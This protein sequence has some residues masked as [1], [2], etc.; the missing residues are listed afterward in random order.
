LVELRLIRAPE[1]EIHRLASQPEKEPA[2]LLADAHRLLIAA[3]VA[4]GQPV[5]QPASGV[6]EELD[7]GLL[8]PDFLIQLPEHGLLEALALTHATLRKLPAA[9]A[10]APPE[11]DLACA[12]HQHDADV[13]AKAIRIDDVSGHVRLLSSTACSEQALAVV[14][15]TGSGH[16]ALFEPLDP[17]ILPRS[18]HWIRASCPAQCCFEQKAWFLLEAPPPAAAGH[19]P[20]AWDEERWAIDG[21]DVSP[22]SWRRLEGLCR[23]AVHGERSVH[24]IAARG[25][26]GVR[27]LADRCCAVGF[28]RQRG[29]QCGARRAAAADARRLWRG[30]SPR[31]RRSPAAGAVSQPPRRSVRTGGLGRRRGRRI[32]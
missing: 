8:E 11:E 22:R 30:Q 32:T 5:S 2:L 1:I 16:P 14:R 21:S 9:P 3:H 29:S 27:T 25:Q 26:C 28:W 6:P 24:R 10:R 18:R 4:R 31:A 19:T 15:C 7:V 17:G 13:R 20:C 12:A 23:A